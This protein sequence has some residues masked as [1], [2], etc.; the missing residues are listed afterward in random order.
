[1]AF[2]IDKLQTAYETAYNDFQMKKYIEPKIY[3]GGK[4]FDLKKRWYIYYSFLD[5]ATGRM[6]RQSPITLKVN[7]RFKTKR[8]RLY[9]LE[10]IR[11]LLLNT[12]KEGFNPY[13]DNSFINY[14]AGSCLDYGLLVKKTEI[15]ETTYKSLNNFLNMKK[16]LLIKNIFF[17]LVI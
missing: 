17:E 14:T 7:K 4:A 10:I 3:H 8:E 15:K 9:N 12:L 6:K 16:E 1:M 5:P 11:K 13:K 2:L